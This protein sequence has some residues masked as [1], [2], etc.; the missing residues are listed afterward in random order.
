MKLAHPLDVRR[1][2]F[3]ITCT[4]CHTE[5]PE[6]D[7]SK[8]FAGY[9]RPKRLRTVCKSCCRD[10]DTEHRNR[11][12]LGTLVEAI[13]RVDGLENLPCDD[14]WHYSRCAIDSVSCL[15]F[16]MWVNDGKKHRRS[17]YPDKTLDGERYGL[18]F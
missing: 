3:M 10:R 9:G 14:C 16:R 18:E 6:S 12:S 13:K 17:Q 2:I 8:Y 5:K 11:V 4:K 7:F 15:N 1:D